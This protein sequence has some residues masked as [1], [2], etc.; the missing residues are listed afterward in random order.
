V[1]LVYGDANGDGRFTGDDIYLAVDWIIGR[2]SMPPAD[3]PA[4][5]AADVNGDGLIDAAEVELLIA[6]YLGKIARFP[7][8]P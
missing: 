3:T 2:N 5:V 4:F 1:L 6:R 7:V 8:E